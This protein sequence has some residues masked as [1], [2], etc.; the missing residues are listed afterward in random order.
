VSLSR[1]LADVLGGG[2]PYFA[3]ARPRAGPATAGD[4]TRLRSGAWRRRIAPMPPWSSSCALS[5]IVIPMG[6]L[7]R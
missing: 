5:N 2:K 6:G 1:A 4:A 7:W 3:G